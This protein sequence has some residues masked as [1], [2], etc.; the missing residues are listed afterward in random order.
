M[1]S[2]EGPSEAV[3]DP[4]GAG[5]SCGTEHSSSSYSENG[6]EADSLQAQCHIHCVP[7]EILLYIFSFLSVQELGRSVEPVCVAWRDLA[8]DPT[9]RKCFVFS[10][11]NHVDG[12]R[13]KEL[14]AGAPL[15]LTLELQSREDGE[16]LL[17][18]AASFCPRLKELT[19]KF[20]D[21]LTEAVFETLKENCSRLQKLNIE[22]SR[23]LER[24]CFHL[25]AGFLHLRHL[26]LSHCILLED[27]GLITIAKQCK[28]LEYLD[29]DG[30]TEIHDTSVTFLTESLG[31]SLK[32]LFLDGEKLTNASYMS[33]RTCTHLIKLGVS[34]CEKM[35]DK[36]LPGILGLRHLTWI[37][38]RKG[39]QLTPV[40][41]RS[42]FKD[43]GLPQLAYINL[44]E[45]AQL[46]DSVLEAMAKCCPKLLH[47]ALHWCWEVTDAGVSAIIEQCPRL[48]VLD[49]VGVVQLTGTVFSSVP[50]SLPDLLI[51]DL[52][53]CNDVDDSLLQIVVSQKP[54]L[55][56]F[57][58]W[59][60]LVMPPDSSDSD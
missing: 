14:L 48:R 56:V 17:L 4:D 55:R 60:D 58:Y 13:V 51:L 49:L 1:W 2:D 7:H 30:I 40:G 10:F 42:L 53:Q 37:K 20:C 15:L 28:S 38:L 11:Q 39:C 32:Y 41:L 18:H 23:V 6:G 9:L 8:K 12:E 45:C 33:L 21:G 29:I 46:D 3:G 24:E 22:G 16:D 34:F 52:E 54:S 19:V 35:T 36:G 57:D 26:N 59:G 31:H 50:T 27:V 47:L 44:G 5:V 25:I 43:A